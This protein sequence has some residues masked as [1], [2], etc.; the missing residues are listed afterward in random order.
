MNHNDLY[1]IGTNKLRLTM[2]MVTKPSV[3]G[4]YLLLSCPRIYRLFCIVLFVHKEDY[5]QIFKRVC[6]I[7]RPLRLVG[8][9]GIRK[10]V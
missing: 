6:L 1:A 9:L 7:T 4:I 2:I 8:R 10:R 5:L 3:L